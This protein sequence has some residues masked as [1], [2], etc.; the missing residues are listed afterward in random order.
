[1]NPWT[2]IALHATYMAN[3]QRLAELRN[4]YVSDTLLQ[5]TEGVA[6]VAKVEAWHIAT[7]LLE[8]A[9]GKDRST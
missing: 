9:A 6:L 1:M 2:V 3:A 5:Y 4:R 8:A 7:S